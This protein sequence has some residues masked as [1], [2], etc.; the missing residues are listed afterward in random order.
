M[1]SPARN[2]TIPNVSLSAWRADH[3]DVRP[4]VLDVGAGSGYQAA[5]LSELGAEVTAIEL[6]ATLAER[7]S[8]RLATIGYDVTVVVGDGSEGYATNAPYAGIVVA[9]A[10]PDVPPPL[11]DQ[12]ADG[13]TLI[14]PIGDRGTQMLT[15]IR[16]DGD[17]LG[18]TILE[19][20]VFVPLLGRYGFR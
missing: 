15:A 8:Q 12:L 17:R 18:R 4:K 6:N 2:G 1:S 11:M 5:V 13:G 20:V 7:A 3:P 9:A 14:I 10:A 19:P 16:R